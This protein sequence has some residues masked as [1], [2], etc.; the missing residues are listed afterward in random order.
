LSDW[1]NAVSGILKSP[2]EGRGG[3]VVL[4][5]VTDQLAG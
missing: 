1:F 4:L 2:L 5:D 3:F